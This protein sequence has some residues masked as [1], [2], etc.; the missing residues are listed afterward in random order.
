MLAFAKEKPV[1]SADAE[2]VNAPREITKRALHDDD[3][4]VKQ[5]RQ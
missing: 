5:V 4:V 3:F 1:V 2:P